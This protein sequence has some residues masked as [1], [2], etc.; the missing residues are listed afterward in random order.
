MALVVFTTVL[1]L[2]NFHAFDG[3]FLSYPI[4]AAE[5][6]WS[7]NLFAD[8]GD[9]EGPRPSLACRAGARCTEP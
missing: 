8:Q 4:S 1:L 6:G 3:E 7:R 9:G 2:Q 5:N